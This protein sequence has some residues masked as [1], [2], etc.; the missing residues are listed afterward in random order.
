MINK[1]WTWILIFLLSWLSFIAG[2]VYQHWN[3]NRVLNVYRE[4][5]DQSRELI[6]IVSRRNE[7]LEK[8]AGVVTERLEG[9]GDKV[10]SKGK[11]G[12]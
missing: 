10:L 4:H 1:S 7:Q 9:Q 5:I 12:K 3:D 8:W 6:D 11:K 2:A